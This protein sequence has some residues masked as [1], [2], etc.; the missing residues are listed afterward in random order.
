LLGRFFKGKV[1]WALLIFFKWA[2]LKKPGWVFWF[3]FFTTTLCRWLPFS[4]AGEE[5]CEVGHLWN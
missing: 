2:F 3:V 4:T 5:C 1:E